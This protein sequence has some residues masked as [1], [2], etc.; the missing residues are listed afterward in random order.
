[1]RSIGKLLFSMLFT[2]ALA[3]TLSTQLLTRE[4]KNTSIKEK[5]FFT[6]QFSKSFFFEISV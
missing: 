6:I 4:I 2:K 1:M 3:K 5:H